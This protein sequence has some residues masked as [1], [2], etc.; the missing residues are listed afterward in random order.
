MKYYRLNQIA[1]AVLGALLLFF[2]ARTVIQILQEEHEPEKPGYEV[3]GTEKKKGEGKPDGG[4]QLASLLAGADAARGQEVAKK[5]AIC[6]TFDKGGAN[7]IGPNLFGVLGAKMASHEG[8]EYSEA[9]KAKGGVWDYANLDHMIENPNA[10]APGTKMALFPGLPDAKQRADVILFLRSKNDSPPPLPEPTA[11]PAEE[12]PAAEAKTGSEVLALLATAD[13]KQGEADAALCKVCHTFDKGG[14]V[15]VGPNLYGI[16]GKKI[17]SQEGV[18][19]TAALKA[20]DG[21]WTYEHLD[22]WLTNPQAFAPGTTMAFPG[23]PDAKKRANIVAFMRSKDDTPKPLP[24]AA[25]AADKAAPREAAPPAAEAPAAPTEAAPPAAEAPAAPTEAAPP[26]AEAPAAPTEA[27]PPAAEAPA[28]PMEPAPPAAEAPAAP[29]EAAP[30]AAEAPAAPAGGAEIVA[31]IA[32]ADPAQGE[33]EAALCKVCHT[34][35]KGGATLIGPNLYDIVGKKIAAREGFTYSPALKAKEGDWTYETL[36]VWLANPQAFA[37]G[38]T[39]MLP[40]S[41]DTKKRA[42]VVAFMRS[43]SDSPVPLPDA[44]GEAA[45]PAGE[46][47]P[48]PTEPA[49]PAAE[50]PPA[51]TE[52]APPA[53]ETPPAP[54]E[55]APPA[56]ATPPAPTEPAPPAAETPLAA[57]PEAPAATEPAPAAESEPAAE[58]EPAVEAEPTPSEP[59]MGEPPSPSQPQPVYPDVEPAATKTPRLRRQHRWASHPPRRSRSRSIPRARRRQVSEIRN[60]KTEN[61]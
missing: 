1:M 21:D 52:P 53:A 23:V 28:A 18:N 9:L 13:P 8:Y 37:P 34:F 61:Q 39:M 35:D 48:A 6:H 54:T 38:T 12:A 43:K 14:A 16:V 5:C 22:V 4:A 59:S 40:A 29:T 49:P 26:A 15:L 11:A 36:D 3:A 30:P 47:P 51:P 2:G 45:K 24:E 50:T 32:T 55:P 31:L 10:F 60:Q 33:A 41:L 25:P 19:Y 46:T 56:A 27:A 42:N 44:A 57:A 20:K 58:P 17:A 7:L